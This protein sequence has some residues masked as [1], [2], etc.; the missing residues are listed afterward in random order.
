M[1]NSGI[2]DFTEDNKYT[3]NYDTYIQLYNKGIEI[4]FKCHREKIYKMKYFLSMY[5][6]DSIKFK[7][8]NKVVTQFR[9]PFKWLDVI[10]IVLNCIYKVRINYDVLDNEMVLDLLKFYMRFGD[11]IIDSTNGYRP[12]IVD[13]LICVNNKY[14]Y[15]VNIDKNSETIEDIIRVSSKC[16]SKIPTDDKKLVYST[17][18]KFKY[19]VSTY[20]KR[21]ITTNNYSKIEPKHHVVMLEYL[22]LIYDTNHLDFMLYIIDSKMKQYSNKCDDISLSGLVK[23]VDYFANIFKLYTKNVGSR[24]IKHLHGIFKKYSTYKYIILHISLKKYANGYGCGY[25]YDYDY[26][27]DTTKLYDP[28][29][30]QFSK[31]IRGI[32][33]VVHDTKS[34][35]TRTGSSEKGTTE[36]TEKDTKN[37][38]KE[39]KNN[40]K[41]EEE[42][43]IIQCNDI[44]YK[45]NLKEL[46]KYAYF[47]MCLNPKTHI[48]K[49]E[50]GYKIIS[51][52][53]EYSPIMD[54]FSNLIKNKDINYK[55]ISK[56][57]CII[58]ITLLDYINEPVMI[59]NF[60]I[61]KKQSFE[62]GIT[63]IPISLL[64]DHIT[65]I[66]EYFKDITSNIIDNVL[67]EKI[68]NNSVDTFSYI[69]FIS[70]I[71]NGTPLTNFKVPDAHMTDINKSIIKYVGV[72]FRLFDEKSLSESE[73]IRYEFNKN[74]LYIYDSDEDT[75]KE[76]DSYT[77]IG[78]T[79]DKYYIRS[80]NEIIF[81]LDGISIKFEAARYGGGYNESKFKI[82]NPQNMDKIIGKTIKSLYK[83][84]AKT[85][86]DKDYVY[87][88]NFEDGTRFIFH[89]LNSTN[90]YYSGGLEIMYV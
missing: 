16:I 3:K 17:C 79:I 69:N 89:I 35:F 56:D 37:E 41:I 65:S 45:Y 82:P 84:N 39:M 63:N 27:F 88:I 64:I 66:S 9:F 20:H 53:D 73:D 58:L 43:V 85:G 36:Y 8:V 21:Y 76:D 33:G 86:E 49:D 40:T 60:I 61:N 26:D 54:I 55:L 74:S 46:S 90:G 22:L 11:E 68:R 52:E 31:Y 13:L 42:Y 48:K 15:D 2:V 77:I 12:Y 59:Y 83:Y 23:L 51:L 87:I 29:M 72:L 81:V 62:D 38:I 10:E 78:K 7:D 70:C 1:N 34:H 4:K 44:D 14:I 75:G 57:K 32:Y 80:E 18:D 50:N 47:K 30:L 25:G 28:T 67:L 19:V 24:K 71:M 5:N 6:N